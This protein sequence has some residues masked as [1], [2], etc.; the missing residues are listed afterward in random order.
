MLARATKL[1]LYVFKYI[2]YLKDWFSFARLQR[3]SGDARFTLSMRDRIPAL[4]EKS[5][6]TVF[7]AHYVY[8]NAWAIRSVLK[9]LPSTH[10]D[11]SSTLYFCTSLS[12]SIPVKFF[13]YRPAP[14]NLSQLSSDRCD[15]MRLP[16]ADG[17]IESL[18][19]MHT[20][21]HVGLGRY[22]DKIDP[23]GDLR[24]FSELKR[25]VAPGGNLL[26][27]LPVGTQRLCFNAHR[28]YA[29]DS[30][31]AQFD[32]YDLVEAALVTDSGAFLQSASRVE[33]DAQHYGC[34]CFWFRKHKSVN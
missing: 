33:F 20:I 34:G 5:E 25:V 3:A 23:G 8:H 26:V 11:I 17:S 15:L 32:G 1:L 27:V 28:I 12:A 10:V 30:V 9:I 18:S 2:D 29:Y 7:D 6:Q 4:W 21:E 31:L 19:C 16:F 24:A 14:L 22:G 13:D